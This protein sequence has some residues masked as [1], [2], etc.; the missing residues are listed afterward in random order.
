MIYAMVFGFI[1]LDFV[2]GMIKAFATH[3][4]KS[5]KMR[6]GLWHKSS[7]VLVVVLGVMIDYAQTLMDIGV[8]VPV[9]GAA[10]A[11]ITLMEISS[12]LENVCVINPDLM[13]DKLMHIFG[14]HADDDDEGGE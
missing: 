3:S 1:V 2:T 11:Y 8:M 10:C 14:M 9:S 5:A 6:E 13:P 4:F 7:L 12:V